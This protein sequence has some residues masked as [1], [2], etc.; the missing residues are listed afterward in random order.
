[1]KYSFLITNHKTDYLMSTLGQRRHLDY[2]LPGR[3]ENIIREG[4]FKWIENREYRRADDSVVNFAES[5]GVT[6]EEVA[7]FLR[8]HLDIKYRTLRRMLRIHD[9]AVYLLLFNEK[10][11]RHIGKFVGY[12]DS[13]NFRKQFREDTC[14]NPED[15]RQ[16]I[17]R[18]R[19]PAR[20][21]HSGQ[22][23]MSP[24]LKLWIPVCPDMK[25]VPL[26]DPDPDP[27]QAA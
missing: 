24:A 12:T 17:V 4:L 13:S 18:K 9:A 1:M 23:H 21:S 7:D 5:L 15:W 26:I 19:K 10:P 11:L 2:N 16:R 22:P 8:Y 27:D 25:I 20:P 6:E 3:I 14:H